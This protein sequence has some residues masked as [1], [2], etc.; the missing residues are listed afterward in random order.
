[1]TTRTFENRQ[2][3]SRQGTQ[4]ILLVEHEASW[5]FRG[6]HCWQF[7]NESDC[8]HWCQRQRVAHLT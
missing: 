3:T 2:T 5:A 8:F 6:S 1:M 4:V 7:Q